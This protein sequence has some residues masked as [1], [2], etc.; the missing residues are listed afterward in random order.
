MLLRA[1][2]FCAALAVALSGSLLGTRRGARRQWWLP[3]ARYIRA[4]QV[5]RVLPAG[6]HRPAAVIDV[7]QLP[8][9]VTSPIQL[10]TSQS[11]GPPPRRHCGNT[12][13]HSN[14]GVRRLK[15]QRDPIPPGATAAMRS[16]V[17]R[18]TR[19]RLRS[20][21]VPAATVRRRSGPCLARCRRPTVRH[22]SDNPRSIP[23][24]SNGASRSCATRRRRRVWR[25]S[26][27]REA[28]PSNAAQPRARRRFGHRM[29]RA[30]HRR[31]GIC[32]AVA[33]ASQSRAHPPS[34]PLP[35]SPAAP[36]PASVSAKPS[37]S[38]PRR[39]S[40]P[41][42]SPKFSHQHGQRHDQ[43]RSGRP[44]GGCGRATA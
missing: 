4:V 41:P 21:G 2:Y 6:P 32:I 5:R 39:F 22:I 24:T 38:I 9:A 10:A 26:A 18:A 29:D 40:S 12:V 17:H 31:G 36:R 13:H 8:A 43:R 30:V 35:A 11:R 25:H 20:P 27:T 14:P 37:R 42:A 44:A 23:P 33:G 15:R 7:R 1:A 3:A 28:A 19:R 34:A 16:A